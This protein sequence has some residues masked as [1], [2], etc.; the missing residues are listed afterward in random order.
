MPEII[1]EAR[2]ITKRFAG[3]KALDDVS[4]SLERGEILALLGENGAGKSTLMKIV[5]GAYPADGHEGELIVNGQVKRFQSPSD[6]ERA[7][8]GMIHQEILVEPDMSVAENI[9][10]GQFPRKFPGLIDHRRCEEEAARHL[11]ALGVAIDPKAMVRSLAP[12][13]RQIVCIARALSRNPAVL[14][15]DEPTSALTEEETKHLFGIVRTLKE[16]NVS[17]I[18][19]SHKL[20]EVF[21]IADRI[22]VLRDGRVVSGYQRGDFKPGTIIADIVGNRQMEA[23]DLQRPEPGRELL[24]VRGLSIPSPIEKGGY[25]LR[26]IDLSL[27]AGEILGLVGIVGSGRSE[28][29]RAVFGVQGFSEGTVSIE[30]RETRIH[31]PTEAMAKGVC[32]LTED[33]KYDGYVKTMSVLENMTLTVFGRF[34]RL[35]I[36]HAREREAA[37]STS[38]RLQVKAPSLDANILSLSGGNQQKVLLAKQLMA[39]PKVLLLDEPTRGVDVGTKKEFYRMMRDLTRQGMGIVVVSS[40]LPEIIEVCDRY[41]V[42]SGG[43]IVARLERGEADE[44]KLLRLASGFSAPQPVLATKGDA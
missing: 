41:V 31:S 26:G 11:D 1:L 6:A 32:L 9:M 10:L 23:G 20:S 18:Y 39:E 30:G 22:V 44:Q 19:I 29:L 27:R 13:Y 17:C 16:R 14:I 3:T 25:L 38:E 21:E 42:L 7:G 40:E 35:L 24:G 5:A 37:G 28:L 36:N 43:R 15:L 34:A 4:V 8:I 33:R 2:N 12:S